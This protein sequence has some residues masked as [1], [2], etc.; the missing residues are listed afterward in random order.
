VPV[1]PKSG[2]RERIVEN[3][4]IFDFSLADQDMAT[5]DG[6]DRTDGTEAATD[7][8]WWTWRGRARNLAARVLKPLLRR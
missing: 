3:G 4:R 1:I 6:L 7:G 5:L 8:K 2:D